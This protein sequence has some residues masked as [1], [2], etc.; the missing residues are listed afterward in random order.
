[1]TRHAASRG[2]PGWQ[3]Y[4][5]ENPAPVVQSGSP[6]QTAASAAFSVALGRIAA[7]ALAGS[8]R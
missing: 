5:Q 3:G 1:M 7:D 8:G 2:T 6:R 4:G